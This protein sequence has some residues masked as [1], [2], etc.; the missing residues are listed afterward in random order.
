MASSPRLR[1]VAAPTPGAPCCPII[2]MLRFDVFADI[3]IDIISLIIFHAL[4]AYAI[5][6]RHCFM[7]PDTAAAT[8]PPAIYH[9]A[10]DV[11]NTAIC[12]YIFFLRLML[13]LFTPLIRYY[14]YALRRA[15]FTY[16]SCFIIIIIVICSRDYLLRLIL[17]SMLRYALHLFAACRAFHERAAAFCLCQRCRLRHCLRCR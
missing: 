3:L 9:Y 2:D 8:P 17:F 16:F 5:L 15:I 14:H 6:I 12:H 1:Q 7:P 11:T 10:I 13:C 4:Y